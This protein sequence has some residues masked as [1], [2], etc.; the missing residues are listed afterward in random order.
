MTNKYPSTEFK[1]RIKSLKKDLKEFCNQTI[2]IYRISTNLI[3][4]YDEETKLEVHERSRKLSIYSYEIEKSCIN[5]MAVEK[6]V[7]S[8]LMYIESTIRVIS[9]IK[10][11]AQLS[12]KIAESS[13]KI[14]K[15]K[16]H[17]KLL[18]DL[19]Y[20]VD[21]VQILLNT[22]FGSFY[23]QDID[24]ARELPEE[25]DKIDDLF[26][27][28]LTQVTEIIAENTDD[29]LAI[30]NILFIARYLERIAD[31]IVNIGDR[32]IFINTHERPS[33]ENLIKEDEN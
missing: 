31:R 25:D 32:V 4:N 27:K 29:A 9:H 23:N 22:G 20:M 13:E 2:E 7:A 16:K 26:D 5:F 24:I 30:I 28:I 3:E 12:N 15:Q 21:Y 17:E 1:H 6:P 11:I 18:G 8:D 33:I 14:Q 19:K 10:R